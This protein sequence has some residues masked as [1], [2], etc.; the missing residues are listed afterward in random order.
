MAQHSLTHLGLTVIQ[1]RFEYRENVVIYLV[2]TTVTDLMFCR[3]NDLR[4]YCR[5]SECYSKNT[6]LEADC[7]SVLMPVYVGD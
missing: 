1:P 2:S 4:V 3:T 7:V 5:M 6:F